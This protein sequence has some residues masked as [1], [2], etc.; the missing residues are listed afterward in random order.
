MSDHSRVHNVLHPGSVGMS[1]SVKPTIHQ[2]GSIVITDQ[3]DVKYRRR[4]FDK[5][6]DEE[7]F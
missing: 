2:E 4:L 5:V 7:L 3:E 1:I 6:S